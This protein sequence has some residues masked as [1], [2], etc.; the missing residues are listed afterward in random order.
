MEFHLF[1]SDSLFGLAGQGFAVGSTGGVVTLCEREQDDRLF[2]IVKQ[3]TIEGS[4]Q[5][6]GSLVLS[7]AED[8]LIASMDNNQM[9]SLKLVTNAQVRARLHSKISSTTAPE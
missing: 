9:Y 1:F 4:A 8:T 3:L 5:N 2:K 6:V 7:P